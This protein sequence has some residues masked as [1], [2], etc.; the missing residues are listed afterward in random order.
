MTTH[1]I[2]YLNL[3]YSPRVLSTPLH[4]LCI[5]ACRIPA[6][7]LQMTAQENITERKRKWK[8]KEDENKIRSCLCY[9]KKTKKKVNTKLLKI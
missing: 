5:V 8:K 1:T 6:V 7:V 2:Y 4:R 9:L 3:S